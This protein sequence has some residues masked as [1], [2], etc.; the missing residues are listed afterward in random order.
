MIEWLISI[1][2]DLL[3]LLNRCHTGFGDWLMFWLSNKYTWIPLYVVLIMLLIQTYKWKGLW[4][5]LFA[6][7][8]IT[9]SD[10]SCT[11]L[12]KNV[13]E[14]L[15]PCHDPEIM[16]MVLLVNGKCGGKYGFISSH[17]SNTFALAVFLT[18]WFRNRFR[19]F[20]WFIF[21]WA[22]LVS[23]SRIYLGVH[24]PGDVIAGA[25]FGSLTGW[26]FLWLS[27]KIVNRNNVYRV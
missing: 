24:F 20:A 15:R 17:A 18:G 16:D 5:I 22:A 3:L 26:F 12:F 6:I 21:P 1:D 2:K 25:L 27:G 14:R 11:H 23:Y 10:Q 7:A 19:Y 4:I 8:A 13:F 9:V